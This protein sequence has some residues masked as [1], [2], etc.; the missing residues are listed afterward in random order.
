M[1]RRVTLRSWTGRDSLLSAG[2]RVV[3]ITGPGVSL[4]EYRVSVL[5]TA[6]ATVGTL[7][8]L[9]VTGVIIA[10]LTADCGAC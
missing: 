10:L 9:L 5:R 2:D 7:A 3:V 6:G 1:L 4:E 8:T